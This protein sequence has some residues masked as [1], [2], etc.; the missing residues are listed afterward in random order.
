[1]QFLNRQSTNSSMLGQK[2]RLNSTNFNSLTHILFIILI[3]IMTTHTQT[4][5]FTN[6]H[7]N[8]DPPEFSQRMFLSVTVTL[9]PPVDEIKLC[10]T[11]FKEFKYVTNS[12]MRDLLSLLRL[13]NTYKEHL[14]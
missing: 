8:R 3:T 13:Q 14:L 11:T 6:K 1:M 2:R 4:M 12:N 5:P 9:R 10:S 7:T